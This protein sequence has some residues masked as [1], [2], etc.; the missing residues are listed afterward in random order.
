MAASKAF[1][2][3]SRLIRPRPE[4]T[5]VVA[6]VD[7]AS[8]DTDWP[9]GV[10][11]LRSPD[12]FDVQRYP[13]IEFRSTGV[14]SNGPD[15]YAVRGSL[16]IRRHHPAFHAGC[17]ARLPDAGRPWR[18]VADFVAKGQLNRSEFGMTSD[19]NLISDHVDLTI[20]V[21]IKLVGAA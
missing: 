16:Q 15:R 20:S 10:E 14:T 8:I 17:A 7:A 4:A 19:R 21:R 3:R 18:R 6:E 1:G 9:E 2:R 12:Y 13:E 5:S 11:M